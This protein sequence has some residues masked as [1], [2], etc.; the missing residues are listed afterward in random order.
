MVKLT[1]EQKKEVRSHLLNGTMS[2]DDI[3]SSYN[4]TRRQVQY[5]RKEAGINRKPGSNLRGKN[6]LTKPTPEA[7]VDKPEIQDQDPDGDE[8]LNKDELFNPTP[9]PQPSSPD[10]P[11]CG[12]CHESGKRTEL[13]EGWNKCP[14][15]GVDL[16]W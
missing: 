2:D 13:Q 16:Q 6:I 15:C 10:T 9:A 7:P 11:I 8:F 1:L 4:I 12:N 3:M 5:Y 14:V